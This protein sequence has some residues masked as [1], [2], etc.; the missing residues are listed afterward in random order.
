[1][2]EACVTAESLVERSEAIRFQLFFVGLRSRYVHDQILGR[3]PE[4]SLRERLALLTPEDQDRLLFLLEHRLLPM[5]R[6]KKPANPVSESVVAGLNGYL[7]SLLP[8]LTTNTLA[9]CVP[10]V[11]G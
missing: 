1:M 6:P 2:S 9:S 11:K 5:H 8:A 10:T 4:E 3:K 7:A